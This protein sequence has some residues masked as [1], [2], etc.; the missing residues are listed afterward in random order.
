MKQLTICGIFLAIFSVGLAYGQP[1]E[2]NLPPEHLQFDHAASRIP[3]RIVMTFGENSE[4]ERTITWR[5]GTQ[6]DNPRIQWSADVTNVRFYR[7]PEEEAASS[8]ALVTL[9]GDTALY[10]SATLGN[11][12]PAQ[13]YVYR[14]GDGT[15]WSE[16]ID[17]SMP[18][19]ESDKFEFIYLGDAQN[20]VLPLWARVIRAANQQAPQAAFVMHAG[21]LINHSQNDYEWGEWFE[22][23]GHIL[24]SRP[25]LITP[26]NHEYV[27]DEEGDK[28]GISPFWPTQFNFPGNGPAGFEDRT[29]YTDYEHTRIICLDSNDGIKEQARWLEERLAETDKDWVIVMFHHPVISGA[30]GRVNRGVLENWKPLL[31][32]YG[33]D[34]VLQGHDH[35]YGRGNKVIS[36]LQQWDEDTGTV[37]V[38][39]VAGRKTY[40]VSEHPWMQKRAGNLQ[41]YQVISIDGQTLSYKAYTLDNKVFDAFDLV[42]RPGQKNQLIERNP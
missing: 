4:T 32:K 24:A 22:A 37:Y 27:K 12:Q 6:A 30:E 19:G 1:F 18:T 9:Q 29:Y 28:T 42:K 10:H 3:D 23:G 39:S 41:T 21:D 36:G 33:V 7:S 26:G 11:L 20:D 2:K 8:T 40:D 14:V 5:T 35:V 34:L 13:P 31:D 16:W 17:F 38:V 15:Y 25:Q